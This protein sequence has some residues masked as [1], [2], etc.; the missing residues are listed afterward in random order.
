MMVPQMMSSQ[1][2]YWHNTQSCLPPL[3]PP[4]CVSGD[5]MWIAAAGRWIPFSNI[6]LCLYAAPVT[7]Y[8]Q[9]H[10]PKLEMCTWGHGGHAITVLR[11]QHNGPYRILSPQRVQSQM[12]SHSLLPC[13]LNVHAVW[14]V[15]FVALLSGTLNMG[16]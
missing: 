10:P 7:I 6:S 16:L 4:L 11:Q 9:H 13:L 3:S 8:Q 12:R 15:I 14:H 5:A 2:S 1:E